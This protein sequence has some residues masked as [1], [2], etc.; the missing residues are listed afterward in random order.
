MGN[1]QNNDYILIALYSQLLIIYVD[2]KVMVV[3]VILESF[4]FY[5]L[6]AFCSKLGCIW[7][8]FVNKV[9][10]FSG[11]LAGTG[12]YSHYLRTLASFSPFL[13]GDVGTQYL[14]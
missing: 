12:K 11:D 10:S 6:L 7:E 8:S 9:V 3:T 4:V 5:F 1:N 2:G 14:E 13:L